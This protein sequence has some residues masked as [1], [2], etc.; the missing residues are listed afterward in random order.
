MFLPSLT[1]KLLCP[2][3]PLSMSYSGRWAPN[4]GRPIAGLVVCHAGL[5]TI[6]AVWNI[7]RGTVQC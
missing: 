4:A 1:S 2:W 5:V 6:L 3:T 7:V